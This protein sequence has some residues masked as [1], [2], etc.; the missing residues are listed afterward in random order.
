V[1]DRQLV[2][3]RGAG[4]ASVLIRL[5]ALARQSAG[6]ERRLAVLTDDGGA[7]T[8]LPAWCRLTGHRYEGVDGPDRYLLTLH[9]P[10][11]ESPP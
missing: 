2:E 6:Q 7:P 1:S 4:C 10:T 5:A 3:L 8:E 9:P 11:E